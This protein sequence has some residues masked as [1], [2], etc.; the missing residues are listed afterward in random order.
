MPDEV[1]VNGRAVKAIND[2]RMINNS[3]MSYNGTI[4]SCDVQNGG[5][6]VSSSNSTLTVVDGSIYVYPKFCGMLQNM[7]VDGSVIIG[8]VASPT[9]ML[10]VSGN[11]KADQIF[12]RRI[13]ATEVVITPKWQ[14]APP[15]YVF[16][17]G[18]KLD[19]LKSIEQYVKVNQHLKDVPSAEELIKNGVQVADLSMILLKKVEEL[20]LH[21]IQLNKEIEELRSALSTKK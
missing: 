19:S 10:E 3:T 4:Y 18:Y 7:K 21:T 9:E 5:G 15:D 17:P 1:K 20:T 12:A 2:L 11:I 14:M 6:T 13:T 8:N 16:A